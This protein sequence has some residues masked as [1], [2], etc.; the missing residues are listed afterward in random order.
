MTARMFTPDEVDLQLVNLLQI[1]PRI[2]W[3]DGSDILGLSATALAARWT[4]LVQEGLAWTSVYPG[5]AHGDHLV[6]I[7]EASVKRTRR[8]E[9]VRTLCRDPRVVSLDE[10]SGRR[11]L[12]LTVMVR[13]LRALG[14]FV[15]DHVLQIP[16][17]TGARSGVVTQVHLEGSSWRLDALDADQRRAADERS[18]AVTRSSPGTATV[19]EAL[20][21]GLSQDARRSVAQLARDAETSAATLQRQ[22]RRVLDSHAI[23]LRCDAAPEL[24]GWQVEW[25]WLAS[26]APSD[27]DR[28]ITTLLSRPELRMCLSV[29]G[30]SNLIFSVLSRTVAAMAGFERFV[31]AEI[32]GLVPTETI[33]HLR[34]HKRM[35]RLI[36]PDGRATGE[37]VVPTLDSAP[38]G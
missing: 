21:A 3:A 11:D 22:L 37:V 20:I 25:S 6:A 14:A 35:G 27:K 10:C 2:S 36:G 31:A 29:T 19:Y 15:L 38:N 34:R 5:P 7:V 32:P 18:S 16:G 12:I 9:V 17:I 13:D 1:S 24:T 28:V 23:A 4:R 8:H 26:V 33:V 30:E